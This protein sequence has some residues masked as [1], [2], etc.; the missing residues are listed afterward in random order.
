MI[1][2]AIILLLLETTS[3]ACCCYERDN[4]AHLIVAFSLH[5]WGKKEMDGRWR[6]VEEKWLEVEEG[7]RGGVRWRRGGGDAEGGWREMKEI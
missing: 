5:Y 4:T 6:E 2:V 3:I 7:R 1:N